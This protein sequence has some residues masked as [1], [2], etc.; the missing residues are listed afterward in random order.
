MRPRNWLIFLIT[1]SL[2]S[3]KSVPKLDIDVGVM[4]PPSGGAVFT[5]PDKTQYFMGYQEMQNFVVLSP[6][7]AKRVYDR[8]MSCGHTTD[9]TEVGLL[10]PQDPIGQE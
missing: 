2:L 4:D 3:C 5:R 7:H 6:A 8:L 10:L 9:V 1:C